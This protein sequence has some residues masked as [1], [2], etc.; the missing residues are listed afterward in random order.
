M[1]GSKGRSGVGGAA[2]SFANNNNN[3]NIKE[4]KQ[5]ETTL[6]MKIP[7]DLYERVKDIAFDQHKPVKVVVVEML[8]NVVE[9]HKG[10]KQR[11]EWQR[12]RELELAVK[13][14]NKS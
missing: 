5:L 3:N 8:Q 14:G 12:E 9:Q 13:R 2:S 6:H 10:V 4:V 11:P 1:G 7:V